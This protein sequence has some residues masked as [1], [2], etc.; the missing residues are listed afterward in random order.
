MESTTRLLESIER[1]F[2]ELTV[3]VEACGRLLPPVEARR[4]LLASSSHQDRDRALLAV[5]ARAR[6]SQEGKLLLTGL[7]LPALRR[8]SGRLTREW[9]AD[10]EDVDAEV[11]LALTEVAAG[12]KTPVSGVASS[13]VWEVH[14]RARQALAASCG[15]GARQRSLDEVG[16]L[17]A[18]VLRLSAPRDPEDLV[19][20]AVRQ[21]V[22]TEGEASLI[23]TTRF[24]GQ[25]LV[26]VASSQGQPAKRLFE[27]RRVAEARLVAMV[28]GEAVSRRHPVVLRSRR[29]AVRALAA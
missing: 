25:E 10:P 8:L 21:G 5:I 28:Q 17:V 12:E 11:C 7:L 4:A 29:Q 24:D 16:E 27:R 19:S 2:S 26:R 3:T 15:E 9:G 18:P 13:V 22:L 1:A 14:R 23:V 6:E 20:G